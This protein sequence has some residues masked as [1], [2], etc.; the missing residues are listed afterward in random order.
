MWH[1]ALTLLAGS[2]E[3]HLACKN[4]LSIEVAALLSVWSEVQMI[5]AALR[6]RCGHYI[7]VPWFLL[8]SFFLFFLAISEPS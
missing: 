8:S 4:T 6:I 3:E 1:S 7:F 2:Q 5:V